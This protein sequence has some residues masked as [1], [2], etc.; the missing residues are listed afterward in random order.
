M[1]CKIIFNKLLSI[2]L[3]MWPLVKL[4]KSAV[5]LLSLMNFLSE[6]LI[7]Q[8]AHYW[9][10]TYGTRSTLLGGAVIGSVD[11]LGATFY[12]PG[13][14]SLT[15][16]PNFLFSAKVFEYN[17]IFIEPEQGLTEGISKQSFTPS[18]GF[19]VANLT[20]EWLG[21]NRLAFSFLTR[22]T[23]NTRFKTRFVGE[24]DT[25]SVSNE[26]LYEGDSDEL[27]GGITWSY[28]FKGEYE[29]GIGI[30][31][32]VAVRN[33]RTRN[34]VNIQVVDTSDNVGILSGMTEYD[35]YN[36]RL[37]WKAGI[38]FTFESV[39]FGLTLTTPSINLFGSGETDINLNSSG[40]DAD[41]DLLPDEFLIS[42]FQ[43]DL[44]SIY[45]SSIAIGFGA[46]YKFS[47]FKMHFAAEYYS[48]VDKFN[49][50]TSNEFQSQTGGINLTNNLSHALSS[51]L[52]IGLGFEYYL[53]AKVTAYGGFVTDFSALNSTAKTNHSISSWNI[54][55][56][57]GG[58]S[59]SFEKLEVTFGL[60][61]GIASD[62]L[63]VPL[64]PLSPSDDVN[65]IFE[66]QNA[67][68]SS[69]RVKFILGLTF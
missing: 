13:N 68:F 57:T 45:K 48:K 46:Y 23:F 6:E 42:N 39:K 69:V 24:L 35:Y 65:F 40:I 7:P 10:Q 59:L 27:W 26:I 17:S 28:P 33:Y 18:P 41:G 9:T 15:D 61:L 63:S 58:G 54:Y 11:D 51:V 66:Q 38:G 31:N 22:Q 2:I 3:E 37:L 1:K 4:I 36:L 47:D 14:L 44:N 5:L 55:H 20:G 56:V 62:E 49:V 16:D 8:D 60:S 64:A 32:Y 12:N 67:K 43:K 21:K 50:L 25:N 34:S 29:L 19:V 30:T 52:N 53:S